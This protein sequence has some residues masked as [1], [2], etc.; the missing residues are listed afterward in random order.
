MRI[1]WF[2]AVAALA[3]TIALPAWP[4]EPSA[5]APTPVVVIGDSL[6]AGNVS[7]IRQHFV[8]VGLGAA[9]FD[10]LSG[11]NITQSILY[12]WG[13]VPSGVAAATAARAA[14][15]DAPLW[16]VQL[17]ANNVSMISR[18]NC[19]RLAFARSMIAEMRAAV[20][21]RPVAWV[22]VR[23]T[24]FVDAVD[25][26]NQALRDEAAADPT[27]RVIDWHAYSAGKDWFIDH[28]HPNVAGV[29]ALGACMAASASWILGQG[30]GVATSTTVA[31]PSTTSSSISTPDGSPT[32]DGA[33]TAVQPATRMGVIAAPGLP[34]CDAL[35]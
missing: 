24:T 3:G 11:R 9:F 27:F 8:D 35:S 25:I 30:S 7:T 21:D 22:N 14:G 17:G 31:T 6:T 20:G 23:A 19:D 13:F 10:A 29:Q 16:V 26:L 15:I 33:A 1:R 32:I 4:G 18:C 28:V 34:P 5:A 2:V 12:S